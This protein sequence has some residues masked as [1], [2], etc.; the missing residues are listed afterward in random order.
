MAQRMTDAQRALVEKNMAL[1]PWYMAKTQTHVRR[2]DWEDACQE[3]ATG[4]CMAAINYKPEEGTTFST[5]AMFYIA[6]YVRH[7]MRRWSRE[8][9]R[10]PKRLEEPV[11]GM[12]E[13]KTRLDQLADERLEPEMAKRLIIMDEL[14][15]LSGEEREVMRLTMR[16]YTQA[17]IAKRRSITQVTVCRRL[18]A[19]R[20]RL[21]ASL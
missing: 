4:L 14:N 12:E 9:T 3:A 1:V 6:G 19:A 5:Y 7:Y 20:K 13:D 18:K 11:P 15:R 21:R 17:E 8:E 16:G 10:C 2:E